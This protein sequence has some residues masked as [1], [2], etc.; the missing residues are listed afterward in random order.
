MFFLS[1]K[2]SHCAHQNK[3]YLVLYI[4]HMTSVAFCSFSTLAA[5]FAAK[6]HSIL[7]NTI[8]ALLTL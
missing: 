7:L 4:I 2:K 6:R 3:I 8:E 5:G 1:S